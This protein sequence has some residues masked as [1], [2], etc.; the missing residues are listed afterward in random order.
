MSRRA[1]LSVYDKVGLA[2]FA[3]GLHALG[4]ELVSSGKTAAALQESGIVVTTVE[5]VTGAPEMLD[6]RV[7]TLHPRVH[8]GPV[9]CPGGAG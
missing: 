7:K 5:E 2:D 4:F 8:G 1:L 6:G 3:A 9:G